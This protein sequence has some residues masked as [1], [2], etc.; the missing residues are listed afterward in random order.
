[1]QMMSKPYTIEL[2]MSVGAAYLS[3]TVSTVAI[4]VFTAT[5]AGSYSEVGSLLFFAA[6]G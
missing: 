6:L 3:M 2:R 1:M 4:V 5:L